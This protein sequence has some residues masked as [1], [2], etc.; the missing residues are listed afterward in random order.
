MKHIYVLPHT[1]KINNKTIQWINWHF[2]DI[3]FKE[4]YTNILLII[5]LADFK[6]KFQGI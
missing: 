4:T 6:E 3:C 1:A 2:K 5:F